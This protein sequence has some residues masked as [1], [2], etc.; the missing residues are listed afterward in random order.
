MLS[1]ER[2]T[3][4]LVFGLSRSGLEPTIYRTGSEHSYY[5]TTDAVHYLDNKL[6]KIKTKQKQIDIALSLVSNHITFFYD[7]LTRFGSYYIQNM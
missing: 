4:N 7:N 1:C 6:W 5:Y 3:I 2:K